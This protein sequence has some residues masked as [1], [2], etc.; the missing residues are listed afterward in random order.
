MFWI[1]LWVA[2]AERSSY[3]SRTMVDDLPAAVTVGTIVALL[4]FAVQALVGH[5]RRRPD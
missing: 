3:S 4:I 2:N 1:V 5:F